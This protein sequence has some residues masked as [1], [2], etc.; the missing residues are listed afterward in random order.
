MNS[1]LS[2]LVHPVLD[3]IVNEKLYSYF[4]VIINLWTL[5]FL[6]CFGLVT[7]V[8]NALV[9]I[10]QGLKDSVNISMMAITF[11]DLVKCLS[12]LIHRMYGPLYALSPWLSFCWQNFTYY[13]EYTP[14]FAGYVN[15][16]LTAYVSVERCLCVSM[17]FKVKSIITVKVTLVMVVVISMITF[18]AFFVVYFL[19][20]IYYVYFP[21]FNT[22]LP[23]F[24]FSAFYYRAQNVVMPYYNTIAILLPFSSFV[25]LC[26]CSTI[27]I[28]Y[29]KKSSKFPG[30]GT[31]KISSTSGISIRERKVSKML[32]V[33]IGVKIGNLFPRM[34]CYTAQLIE[35]EFYTLRHYHYLFMTVT[36]FL[37]VLDIVN[38]SATFFI[39]LNMSS[40]FQNSF[41]KLFNSQRSKE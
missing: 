19:Y 4:E 9:F 31:G 15:F 34:I 26:A 38:A 33:V 10:R 39:Y 30:Q 1:T 41:Y 13:V 24:R 22:S 5:F 20:D 37:F 18:G 29:L 23:L 27:T 2:S 21:E 12:G 16:S 7:N 40:N 36:R 25:V 35:P 8:L 6:F 3:Y 11:W 32:L 28:Y 17:P 14:I